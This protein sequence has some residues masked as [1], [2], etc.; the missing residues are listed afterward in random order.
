MKHYNT[1][2]VKET[3][4]GTSTRIGTIQHRQND[5]NKVPSCQPHNF[6]MHFIPTIENTIN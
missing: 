1:Y 3:G 2:D 6:C 5:P 4:T